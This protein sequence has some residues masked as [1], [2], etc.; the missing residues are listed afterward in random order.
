MARINAS[1]SELDY[2]THLG[3]AK[4]PAGPNANP[5][6]QAAGANLLEIATCTHTRSCLHHATK[7]LLAAAP[8]GA[9]MA[10]AVP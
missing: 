1:G 3:T 5:G 2:L 6:N 8:V 4:Y 9:L 10:A 7:V